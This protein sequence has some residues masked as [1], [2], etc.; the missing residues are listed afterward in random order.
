[1]LQQTPR[2]DQIK[3]TVNQD[4]IIYVGD[5]HVTKDN[6][7]ES[8]R[9]TEWIRSL[10]AK[11]KLPVLFAGDQYNDHGI[12]RVEVIEF[13]VEE[14]S[15]M[16]YR[17]TALVGNHDMNQEGDASVMVAHNH[18]GVDVISAPTH[19]LQQ[20]WGAVPFFRKNEDFIAAVTGL[21]KH[22]C[23]TI[24]CHQEMDGAQ[25]ENGFYSPHGVKMSDL[26]SDLKLISG[27]IHKQQEFGN[28]WYPGAPR[29]LT[30]SDIGE[31]KGVWIIAFDGRRKFIPTPEEV[32]ESF[33]HIK[34]TPETA[35]IEIPVSEKVYI[36]VY[37]PK[38]FVL[39]FVH[40][41]SKDGKKVP[42][43]R[44]Y[45]DPELVTSDI[46][47]SDGINVAFSKYLAKYSVAENLSTEDQQLLSEKI[48][49]L[50]PILK[51]A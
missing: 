40:K 34:V 38:E 31:Q 33:K 32:C 51:R 48:Y 13:W 26:P 27:H 28:V 23:K 16:P 45:A 10:S 19:I 25:F 50:C 39:D 29:Q 11:Y 20:G 44:A 8:R 24:F 43:L 9:L 30:R 36:D 12:Q 6:R 46:K 14:F 4:G 49:E 1:V 17:T 42:H 3:G 15:A 22:G 41:L 35:T 5:M 47:E 18:D 21:Y 2:L 7:P 37:G